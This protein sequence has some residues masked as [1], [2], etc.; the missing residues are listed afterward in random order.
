[1]AGSSS[2]SRSERLPWAALVAA[3][4]VVAAEAAMLLASPGHLGA[5]FVALHEKR[6]LATD[7]SHTDDVIILGDSCHIHYDPATVGGALGGL[8]AT[9]YAWPYCGVEAYDLFLDAYLS[10]HEPP[11]AIVTGLMPHNNGM[12]AHKSLLGH[13][14][15]LMNRVY[16][17]VPATTLAP[18]LVEARYWD[19]LGD[20]ARYLASPPTLRYR[21]S[22][23]EYGIDYLLLRTPQAVDARRN[24]RRRKQ[25]FAATG[26]MTVHEEPFP[27]GG[28][29]IDLRTMIEDYG[30]WDDDFDP[31]VE[32]WLRR[33]LDRAARHG[34]PVIV[35]NNPVAETF[36]RYLDGQG[37]L[38]RH[39]EFLAHLQ[40]D[41]PNL[42]VVHDMP[43]YYDDQLFG[44]LIHVNLRG[45]RVNR[46][47]YM[48]ALEAVRPMLQD[49][50]Q[51]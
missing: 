21:A 12:G 44:D 7:R 32:Q 17:L 10:H 43:A 20:Y 6:A 37:V 22:L 47:D 45:E 5:F 14:R 41:Y 18:R 15:L 38:A 33:Y 36:H 42:I 29:D 30:P 24:E 4:I 28:Y 9:N 34:I 35:L 27:P 3:A 39:E 46:A 40:A 31:R 50:T 51:N 48:R 49:S 13:D 8:R 19:V 26:A 2:T 16:G 11:R 23:R 25:Q 1:M